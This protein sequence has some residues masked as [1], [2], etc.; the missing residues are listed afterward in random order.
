MMKK[1]KMSGLQNYTLN[2]TGYQSMVFMYFILYPDPLGTRKQ[3]I[4]FVFTVIRSFLALN[5]QKLIE[6]VQQNRNT[7]YF[8]NKYTFHWNK[9]TSQLRLQ[10]GVTGKIWVICFTSMFMIRMKYKS[11]STKI[12]F[13]SNFRPK[14]QE[15]HQTSV[16]FTW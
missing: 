5:T 8:T 12:K 4:Y 7:L 6:K 11:Y 3:A 13:L 1:T 15:L 14:R 16:N 2:L 10:I 9:Y